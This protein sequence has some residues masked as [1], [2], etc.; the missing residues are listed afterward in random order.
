MTQKY[1]EIFRISSCVQIHGV[2]WFNMASWRFL[3]D[4]WKMYFSNVQTFS[5]NCT[6][7]QILLQ[8][9]QHGLLGRCLIL[10]S[11]SFVPGHPAQ[12]QYL[13][14]S[15]SM[16]D[17]PQP[18]L[19]PVDLEDVM[20]MS[21]FPPAGTPNLKLD[22]K[23]QVEQKKANIVKSRHFFFDTRSLGEFR[24]RQLRFKEVHALRR[25]FLLA[26]HK[27]VVNHTLLVS[28]SSRSYI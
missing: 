12:V 8:H 26:M 16:E 6:M 2:I 5:L 27:I 19:P 10:D 15:T 11:G 21:F 18:F 20:K 7:W 14:T 13:S 24:S 25:Q 28:Y 9:V 17:K 22:S 4:G 1:H 3:P 23:L